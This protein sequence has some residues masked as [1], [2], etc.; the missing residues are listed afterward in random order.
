MACKK[1]NG[2]QIHVKRRILSSRT[3]VTSICAGTEISYDADNADQK[4]E[5][6]LEVHKTYTH[7]MGI[8]FLI[9]FFPKFL[10]TFTFYKFFDFH[11]IKNEG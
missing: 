11:P 3:E 9:S 2:L 8:I 4:L 10:F 5:W 1:L 7:L 6:F